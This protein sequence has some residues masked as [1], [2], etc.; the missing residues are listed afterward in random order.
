ME[1]FLVGAGSAVMGLYLI[2]RRKQF[3][4]GTVRQQ[5][6]L[7]R[8]NYGAREIKHNERVAVVVGIFGFVLAL[9]IWFDWGW[10]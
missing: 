3:A 10:P 2:A 4:A 8:R 7:L 5:N 6:W 1:H 9:Q